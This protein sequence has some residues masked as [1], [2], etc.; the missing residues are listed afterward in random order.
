M[1]WE[2]NDIQNMKEFSGFVSSELSKIG[3]QR[4]AEELSFF[5]TNTFTT[6]TEYLGELRILFN[7]VLVEKK[8]Y[9][10]DELNSSI[11]LAIKAIN[12]A[13]GQG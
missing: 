7:E 5:T 1:K 10:S 8:A 13:F 11:A 12:K 6:S 4:L 9:F 3:E 2:F